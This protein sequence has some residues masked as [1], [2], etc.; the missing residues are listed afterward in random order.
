MALEDRI[1]LPAL[2]LIHRRQRLL[3][4]LERFVGAGKRLITVYAAS[5]YGKSSL[6]ADFAQTTDLPVCWCSLEASDHDPTTFLSLL[7]YSIGDR[8]HQVEPNKLLRLIEQGN[9]A[10]S[11]RQIAN[12]LANIGPHV[13]IIDDYHKAVNAG[14]ARVLDDLIKQLP[15]TSTLI[16]AAR[17]N[18]TLVTDQV[19]ELLMTDLATGFS[20]DELRFTPGEVQRVMRKRFGRQI[21][22]ET[23]Q[24]IT[25][26]TDGNIAQILL[27]GHVM[28]GERIVTHLRRRLGNDQEIIYRY[29]VAEVLDKQSPELQRFM[30]QTAVLPD[31]TAE[32]CNRFLD[33]TDSQHYLGVLIRKDLFVTQVGDRV[34]YYDLFAQFLRSRLAKNDKLYHQISMKAAACLIEYARF[35]EAIQI[36]LQIQA[37]NEAATVLETQGILFYNTG[38]ALTLYDWLGQMPRQELRERPHLLLLYGQILN[39]SINDHR[40]ALA[41]FRQAQEKFCQQNDAV[42]VAEAYIWQSVALRMVGQAK[43]GLALAIT[44][45]AE[46]EALGAPDK[47]M[48]WA[49]KNYGLAH[50]ISGYPAKALASLRRALKLFEALGDTCQ[51]GL[52]HHDIGVCLEKQGKVK[53]AGHHFEQAL[54]IWES[55]GNANDMANT[56]NSLGVSLCS[57][58]RYEEALKYFTESLDLGLQLGAIRRAAFAQA[59]IGDTYLG[60]NLYSQAIN[61]Y[62]ASTKLAREVGIKNLEIYNQIREGQ[63][64]FRQ[65]RLDEAF[66]LAKQAGEVAVETGLSVEE[67]LANLLQAKIYVR[68]AE[69]T[70]SFKLFE[71]AL[72]ALAHNDILAQAKVRL[73]W[74]YSLL[75]DLRA[76]AAFE[77]L[78]EAIRLSLSMGELIK[79][80][81]QTVAD[82]Q[83]LLLHFLHRLDTP[84]GT[85]DS[86]WLLLRQGPESVDILRPN[87]HVFMFGPPTLIVEGQRKQ[88]NQRGG[89]RK[90]PEFLAYLLIEGQAEG[91]RWSQ[92]SAAIWPELESGRASNV[93]HQHLKRLRAKM[94]DPDGYVMMRD[95][96][97]LVNPEYLTWCDALVFEKLFER[98]MRNDTGETLALQRELIAL[99][100]GQFLA[101]FEVGDWGMAY[102][103]TYETKFLQVVKLAGEQLL[104]LGCAEEALVV[105]E[106]GLGQNYFREDL[107]H[108]IFKAY[109]QLGLWSD[110]TAHYQKMCQIF[111]EELE[112]SPEIET[113]Q[114]YQKLKKE[115]NY[116]NNLPA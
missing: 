92:V 48:A 10:A 56:L 37:W 34:K 94:P 52:C 103:T 26:A 98:I 47:V 88:F 41:V 29:L 87:L 7:A 67:G 116:F 12:L 6:L 31:M 16:I 51:A 8:F 11:I 23:A 115:G 110:L 32:L 93:F 95:D 35:E 59:G 100:Q 22:L 109:A 5:G 102:Q 82:T 43:E 55:L 18:L 107:H 112:A 40:Q 76:E 68:W 84:A 15:D 85:R 25:Q 65:D 79:G 72:V 104:K 74:G 78:Q 83:Q 33:R 19:L 60:R 1:R 49:I 108:V 70:T 63:C 57:I 86:I 91:C 50:W 58:G 3:D 105:A 75:L 38:R 73:W 36:Y 39:D 30:L 114:L 14:L 89:V 44:G 106:K 62:R 20:E 21:D 96:Y 46:L 17:G 97:Y 45:L 69:Y 99:Y 80:L 64:L 113:H 4:L 111:D 71:R 101:G 2:N 9:S 54:R 13:L 90:L 42:G 53:A 24:M 66:R 77:Q 81:Q 27:A 61:A 28:H